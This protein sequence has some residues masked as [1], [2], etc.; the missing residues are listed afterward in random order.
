MGIGLSTQVFWLRMRL[1]RQKALFEKPLC[2]GQI[3]FAT[4]TGAFLFGAGL[5]LMAKVLG[6]LVGH[7]LDQED[8][9][10]TGMFY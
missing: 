2:A 7:L 1:A 5:F 3:R 4:A 10:H 8:A 6:S 9:C